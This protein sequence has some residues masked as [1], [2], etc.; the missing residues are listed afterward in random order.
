MTSETR[1]L[2]QMADIRGVELICA[3]AKCGSKVM[4]SPLS[5]QNT[6][7]TC[8]VCKQGLFDP[9]QETWQAADQLHRAIRYLLNKNIENVRLEVLAKD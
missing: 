3:N 8:P 1:H 9:A 2:V 5:E 4:V 7:T 6:P